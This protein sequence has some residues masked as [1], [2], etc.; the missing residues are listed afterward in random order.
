[1]LK[2][3]FVTS[4]TFSCLIAELIWVRFS[5]GGAAVAAVAAL[6]TVLLSELEGLVSAVGVFRS[7]E[8]VVE[9]DGFALPSGFISPVVVLLSEVGFVSAVGFFMSFEV[10]VGGVESVAFDLPSTF[11]SP[12]AFASGLPCACWGV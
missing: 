1:M 3:T 10:V 6:P 12:V 7:F 5:A 9:S 8:V 11:I 4:S 2:F